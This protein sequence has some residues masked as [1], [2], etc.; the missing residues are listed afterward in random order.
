MVAFYKREVST[1]DAESFPDGDI[2][3][4]ANSSLYSNLIQIRKLDEYTIQ[5]DDMSIWKREAEQNA[6][7]S[8]GL[9][10]YNR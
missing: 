9:P 5:V 7:G 2:Q 4:F 3:V 6:T 10:G 1:A 8:A